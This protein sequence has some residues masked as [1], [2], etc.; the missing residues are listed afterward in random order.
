MIE[1][2]QKIKAQLK[3]AWFPGD[4]TLNVAPVLSKGGKSAKH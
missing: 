4:Y 2:I 1:N 3:V